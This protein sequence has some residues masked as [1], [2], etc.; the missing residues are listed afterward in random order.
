MSKELNGSIEDLLTIQEISADHGWLMDLFEAN[1]IWQTYSYKLD[2]GW[3]NLPSDSES[4]WEIISEYM[5]CN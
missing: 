3:I 5:I 2:A 1:D 4:L